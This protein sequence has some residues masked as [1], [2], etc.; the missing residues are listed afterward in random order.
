[1]PRPFGQQDRKDIYSNIEH[2]KHQ[3]VVDHVRIKDIAKQWNCAPA[4]I[5]HALK[6]HMGEAAYT[7]VWDDYRKVLAKKNGEILVE[8]R[9]QYRQAVAEKERMERTQQYTPGGA[10]IMR[11]HIDQVNSYVFSQPVP[12]ESLLKFIKEE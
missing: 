2:I 1:M 12:G 6:Q 9:K 7:K 8:R 10:E 5:I 11:V 4:T 3:Y